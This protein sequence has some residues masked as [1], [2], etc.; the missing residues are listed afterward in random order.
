[1]VAD[2]WEA[3]GLGEAEDADQVQRAESGKPFRGSF[4]GHADGFE[5]TRIVVDQRHRGGQRG[6]GD[7]DVS[8]PAEQAF[9]TRF[10]GAVGTLRWRGRLWQDRSQLGSE[11]GNHS[12]DGP[13]LSAHS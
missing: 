3:L 2:L 4:D 10:E 8:T 12:V 6:G 13:N 11:Q 1:M 5:V 9:L 7:Q